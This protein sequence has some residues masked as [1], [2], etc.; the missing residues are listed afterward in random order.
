MMKLLLLHL[1]LLLLLPQFLLPPE[2]RSIQ[3]RRILQVIP[4]IHSAARNFIEK[5]FKDP[6][7]MSIRINLVL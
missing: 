7:G 4:I 6:K 2:I 1:L 3:S 5:M